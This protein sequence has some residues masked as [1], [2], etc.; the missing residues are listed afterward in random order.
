MPKKS[1]PTDA[2]VIDVIIPVLAEARK[3]GTS[4]LDAG[5]MAMD[6]L[7]KRWPDM[8]LKRAKAKVTRLR[9]I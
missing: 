2:E 6:A 9:N 3:N 8:P 1:D 4:H 7:R 5:A